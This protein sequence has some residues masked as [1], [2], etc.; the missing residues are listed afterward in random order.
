MT[1]SLLVESKARH[2]ALP[3]DPQGKEPTGPGALR[4]ALG[5]AASSGALL[6]LWVFCLAQLLNLVHMLRYGYEDAI[7][8]GQT[9]KEVIIS[10][11]D[12]ISCRPQGKSHSPSLGTPLFFCFSPLVYGLQ[13]YDASGLAAGALLDGA[14]GSP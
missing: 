10:I 9:K 1:G 4:A 12:S 11:F 6:L 5:I 8:G 7:H 13:G 14:R 3:T 2:S